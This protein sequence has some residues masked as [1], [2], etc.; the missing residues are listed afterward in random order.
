MRSLLAS[1]PLLSLL[2]LACRPTA[3]TASPDD[4]TEGE[5]TSEADWLASVEHR[6]GLFDLYVDRQAARLH[7]AL[8]AGDGDILASCL[9]VDSL[10]TGLGSSAVGLDR[11]EHSWTR[12][13]QFRRVG[14]KVF[15]EAINTA[16]RA[17][18]ADPDER[19]AAADS[20]PVS[21][22]WAG[23][24]TR[25]LADGRIVVDFTSFAVSD[26]HD[27]AETL[28]DAEQGRF[29]L[30]AERSTF[31][32]SSVLAFPENLEFEARLTFAGSDVGRHASRSTPEAKALSLVVHHS[33]VKLPDAA[34]R[35]RAWH[36]AAGAIDLDYLDFATP[37]GQSLTRQLAIRHRLIKRP[38][39]NE[40]IEP[41]VY[42]V[43]RGAPEPIRSALIEGASWWSDA[44]AAAGFDNAFRVELLPADAHPLDA[45]YNVIT[46]VHRQRRGWSY[47]AS[48]RDPRTGEIIK[49]N[50]TLGS[51]RVRQDILLFEGLVGTSKT[52]SGEP[53]DPVQVALARIRQLSAHEVGHT[54]GLQH[55]FA[56][57]TYG[58][59]SV[60]DYPA[61]HAK[62][63]D[64]NIDLSEAYG[65]GIGQWDRQAIRYLYSEFAPEAEAAGLRA[66]LD[67]SRDNGWLYLND[68]DARRD[69]SAHPLASLWDNGADPIAELA[70]VLG[71]RRVAMQRFGAD[72]VARF[73]EWADLEPV[74]A[75]LYF[76]HRYQQT[77]AVKSVGGVIYDRGP[78]TTAP[79]MQPVAASEQRRALAAVLAIVSPETLDVPESVL[80]LLAPGDVGERLGST[81]WPV[82]DALGAA[83]TAT[84][85]V[86]DELLEP[87]RLARL[88]EFHRRDPAQLGVD[89]LLDQL[90]RQGFD[91][92]PTSPRHRE[93]AH[94]IQS[95]IVD[96]LI[97]ASRRAD[98][99]AHVRDRIERRLDKLGRRELRGGQAADREHRASLAARVRRHLERRDDAVALPARAAEPPPGSPIGMPAAAM[100]CGHDEPWLDRNGGRR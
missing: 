73:A 50:V 31:D 95:T 39:S 54:L 56:A 42:Y 17:D 97:E 52:G 81:T 48:I 40:P 82:F 13:I 91:S 6:G 92:K 55:N 69:Q 12:W 57:S 11:G 23:D 3:S 100:G 22:L 77:S 71:V 35:P 7:L 43:D 62:L 37:L 98:L 49:G 51:Q 25:T 64:G 29:S 20:F 28:G 2:L 1:S 46:W 60:M 27:I 53:D 68:T 21:V 34:Y 18:S 86:V 10:A 47:G 30:D 75:P 59:A 63:V 65:V 90:V 41:I 14:P 85:N 89:E 84:R 99:P 83:A 79:S 78:R 36:A 15:V 87:A 93:L 24:V 32:P 94:V 76:H 26:A 19:K 44:F 16:F 70:N 4:K 38:G 61:P 45:R 67:E 33:L 58:R 5:P 9:Y 72:N 88:V 74:F 8:P 96:A 66:I 80:R